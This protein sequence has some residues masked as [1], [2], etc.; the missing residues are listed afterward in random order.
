MASSKRLDTVSI[1][2]SLNTATRPRGHSGQ[3]SAASV[4]I[5]Q[6]RSDYRKKFKMM[7]VGIKT[8]DSLP[9]TSWFYIFPRTKPSVWLTFPVIRSMCGFQEREPEISTPRYLALVTDSKTC[10]RSM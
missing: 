9:F 2:L 7:I 4:S 5:R 3:V 10:P 6:K 1:Y 8:D